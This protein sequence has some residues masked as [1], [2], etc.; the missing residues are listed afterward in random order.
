MRSFFE[1]KS[2]HDNAECTCSAFL[3]GGSYEFRIFK[4]RKVTAELEKI[5]IVTFQL[6]YNA[7]V[8]I[9][10]FQNAKVV[11]SAFSNFHIILEF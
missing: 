7:K 6:F 11:N 4:R 2:Y 8:E 1:D 9:P 10:P 5:R 3:K